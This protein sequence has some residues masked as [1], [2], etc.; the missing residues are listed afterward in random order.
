MRMRVA[1]PRPM[2]QV[3][4]SGQLVAGQ[5]LVDLLNLAGEAVVLTSIGDIAGNLRIGFQCFPNLF[6]ARL[7]FFRRDAYQARV[8]LILQDFEER[9]LVIEY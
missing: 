1:V 2:A 3:S 4:K 8:D 6:D 9:L 7:R 5:L